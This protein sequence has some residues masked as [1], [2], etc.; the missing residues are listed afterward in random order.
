MPV[1]SGA[2]N[3]YYEDKAPA[4]LICPENIF[5]RNNMSRS[6]SFTRSTKK[7]QKEQS[8]KG[9]NSQCQTSSNHTRWNSNGADTAVLKSNKQQRVMEVPGH[10]E[11]KHEEIEIVHICIT[12]LDDFHNKSLN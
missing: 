6:N 12:L 8:F 3:I 9:T 4:V 5:A 1:Q 10:R 7:D 2:G 11:S